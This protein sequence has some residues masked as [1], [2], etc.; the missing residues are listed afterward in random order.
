MKIS[1]LKHFRTI[2]LKDL[3]T[4]SIC[5]IGQGVGALFTDNSVFKI[6]LSTA[7]GTIGIILSL[8]A[9]SYF[10]TKKFKLPKIALAD[11]VVWFYLGVL[12]LFFIY[13]GIQV[14]EEIFKY[15]ISDGWLIWIGQLL[16]FIYL[17]LVGIYGYYLV[18]TIPLLHILNRYDKDVEPISIDIKVWLVITIFGILISF[19]GPRILASLLPYEMKNS[20][21]FNP[22]FWMSLLFS[23]CIAGTL[24]DSELGESRQN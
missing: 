19:L 22:S 12:L 15:K 18:L 7:L 20:I 1:L 6:I 17:F 2:K 21:I 9:Y 3:I 16:L 24:F 8:F 4:A 5:S 10:Q 14:N 23:F 13:I 11:F